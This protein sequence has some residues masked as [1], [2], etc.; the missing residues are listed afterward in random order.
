MKHSQWTTQDWKKLI[1]SDESKFE[2]F[3]SSCRIPKCETSETCSTSVQ[4]NLNVGCLHQLKYILNSSHCQQI[5]H[6]MHCIWFLVPELWLWIDL[7]VVQFL[8]T[9]WWGL[10][11]LVF[12]PQL[13]NS[14]TLQKSIFPL[15]KKTL[16][17]FGYVGYGLVVFCYFFKPVDNVVN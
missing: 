13:P 6:F 8:T 15:N 9:R 11:I 1:W 10:S 4:F 7:I 2:L 3:G 12:F 5:E 17:F 14:C 16:C